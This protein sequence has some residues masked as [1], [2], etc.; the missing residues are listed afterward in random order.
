MYSI[1]PLYPVYDI[2]NI[3]DLLFFK[4]IVANFKIV[5]HF[6]PSFRPIFSLRIHYQFLSNFFHNE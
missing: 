2:P 4:I 5:S 6:Y 3:L 1:Y